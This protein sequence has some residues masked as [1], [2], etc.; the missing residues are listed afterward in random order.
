[1][2]SFTTHD[3]K[4]HIRRA[5]GLVGSQSKL[6][7]MINVSQQG[8]S[9]LCDDGPDGIQTLKAEIAIA[10]DQATQGQVAKEDLRPD[11]FPRAEATAA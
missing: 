5:V 10:V 4:P 3:W 2:T 6:G 8:V 7:K 11:L 9:K 1:M